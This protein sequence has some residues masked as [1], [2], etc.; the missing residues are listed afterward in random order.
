MDLKAAYCAKVLPQRPSARLFVGVACVLGKP[1]TH[2]GDVLAQEVK[3]VGERSRQFGGDDAL[4]DLVETLEQVRAFF[5][6]RLLEGC[7]LERHQLPVA[8]VNA[9]AEAPAVERG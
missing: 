2:E 5:R 1:I 8:T 6:R 4:F 7:A 9:P 3:L